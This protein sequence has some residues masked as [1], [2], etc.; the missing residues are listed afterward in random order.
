MNFPHST[1][2]ELLNKAMEEDIKT[3]DLSSQLTLAKSTNIQAH[4]LAKDNGVFAGAPILPLILKHDPKVQAELLVQD[5]TLLKVGDVVCTFAGPAISLL[6]IE[7]TLLNFWQHLS[8]VASATAKFVQKCTP[9]C[10][11]L[12]TRKT[13]PGWRE[14]QKYAVRCGGGINHRMGLYDMIMLK[15]NH[16]L[17]AGGIAEAIPQVLRNKPSS[18]DV[19]VEVETLA[20]LEIALTFPILRVLLDNMPNETLE[21]AVALKNKIAPEIQLEA[22]GNMTLDRIAGVSKTGVNYISVGALT[23]SV[24]ALDLSM[25]FL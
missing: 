15:E 13:L 20:Q 11:I 22:S 9:P 21:K 5:G 6:E 3:G 4:I 14:L 18:V 17:A 12:D 8:G 16:L 2:A 10:Q 24:Q 19:E 23:H 25:R 1:A 7:R